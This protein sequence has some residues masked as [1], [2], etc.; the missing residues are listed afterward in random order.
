MRNRFTLLFNDVIVYCSEIRLFSVLTA[1]VLLYLVLAVLWRRL[2]RKSRRD[3]QFGES[4]LSQRGPK[5]VKI[6]LI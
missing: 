4:M 3:H 2:L 1:I 5:L 6:K